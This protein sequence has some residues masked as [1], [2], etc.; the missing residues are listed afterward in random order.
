MEG[1]RKTAKAKVKVTKPGTGKLVIKH[2]D[3]PHIV[4]DI[5]Y[6]FGQTQDSALRKFILILATGAS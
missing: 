6:F 5:T 3:F 4:N 2:K 1:R